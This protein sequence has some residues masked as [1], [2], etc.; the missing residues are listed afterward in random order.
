MAV[1]KPG[2]GQRPQG[3]GE[4][5]FAVQEQA[6]GRC[7]DQARQE[8]RGIHGGE[9][10]RKEAQGRSAREGVNDDPER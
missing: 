1:N 10:E 8:V 6:D 3:R 2:W 5:T 4:E 7:L 9:E